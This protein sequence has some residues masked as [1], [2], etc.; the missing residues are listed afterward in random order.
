MG[1]RTRNKKKPLKRLH[2][3]SKWHTGVRNTGR[4]SQ[5]KFQQLID[6]GT[7]DLWAPIAHYR[8]HLRVGVEPG[9]IGKVAHFGVYEEI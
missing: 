7:L 2:Y 3:F 8:N 1:Y 4:K 5:R 6:S 9:V